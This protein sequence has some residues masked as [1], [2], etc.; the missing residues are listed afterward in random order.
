MTESIL[1]LGANS[2]IAQATARYFCLDHANFLLVARNKEQLEL[3]K[4]DLQCRG[5]SNV[6]ILVCDFSQ[7]E[8]IEKLHKVLTSY[9]SFDRVLL[10]YGKLPNE[11]DCSQD[12]SALLQNYQINMLSPILQLQ[13][14]IKHLITQKKKAQIAVISSVAGD[15]GRASNLYYGSA[16]AGLSAYLSGLRAQLYYHG[17]NVLTIKPGFVDTPMTSH[18]PKNF[19]FVKPATVGHQ[20][21]KAM[22]KRKL[23]L[24]TPSFWGLIMQVIKM[25]PEKIFMKMRL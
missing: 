16:K 3:N 10:A 24:Y 1:I 7:Q 18:I 9:P 12:Q 20:I 2:A 21:Y 14:I 17:I 6:D 11:L 4:N 5:A 13:F 25:L 23:V 8:S 19:L 22:K 15:R